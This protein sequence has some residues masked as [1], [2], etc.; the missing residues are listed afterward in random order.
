MCMCMYVHAHVQHVK[1]IQASEV[2]YRAEPDARGA[3]RLETE[4]LSHFPRHLIK[5]RTQPLSSYMHM[6]LSR[7][8]TFTITHMKKLALD[9]EILPPTR[10][11]QKAHTAAHSGPCTDITTHSPTSV[12]PKSKR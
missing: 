7:R 9:R 5:Y 8:R 1:P 6:H 12:P 2:T 4:R 10:T 11:D 3:S